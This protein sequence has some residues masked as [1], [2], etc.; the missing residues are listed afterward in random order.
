ML[1]SQSACSLSFGVVTQH[2]LDF[3]FI[4]VFTTIGT[5]GV[6]AGL[7]SGIK[8]YYVNVIYTTL[9]LQFAILYFYTNVRDPLLSY[10]RAS[11]LASPHR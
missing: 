11:A 4:T 5:A 8:P 10:Q 3:K 7:S 2:L 1:C 6:L 9:I